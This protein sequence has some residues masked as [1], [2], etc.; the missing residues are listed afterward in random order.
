[1]IKAVIFDIDG[2]LLDSFEANLQFLQNL[3]A[4]FGYVGPSRESYRNLFHLSM[5]EVIKVVTG[6]QS[7]E[8]IDKIYQVGASREVYYDDSLLTM[9]DGVEEVLARLNKDYKLGIVTSRVK[10]SVY[11]SPKLLRFADYFQ[12]V[13]SFEETENH[14]PH[15]D[16]L[17]FASEQFGLDPSECVYI[18][19]QE[20]DISAARSA[21]M[22]IIVYSKTEIPGANGQTSIFSEIPELIAKIKTD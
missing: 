17:L 20:G 13:V 7:E 19:D 6:L 5:K 14:K 3:F 8:E 4:R 15:P 22:N 10:S 9:P 16:P 12:V 2:V 21:S 1:M 18:G 11:E